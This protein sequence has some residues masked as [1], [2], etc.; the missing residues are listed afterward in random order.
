MTLD[1]ILTTM[2]EAIA[3]LKSHGQRIAELERR[4]DL[5]LAGIDRWLQ[6]AQ[7]P[8]AYEFE[9]LMRHLRAV[10]AEGA[11]PDLEQRVSAISLDTNAAP[12]DDDP[13]YSGTMRQGM[14]GFTGGKP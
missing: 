8:D 10:L 3:R 13:R 12:D 7:Y 11:R 2:D 1:E 6:R 14:R 5:A 9:L 4:R